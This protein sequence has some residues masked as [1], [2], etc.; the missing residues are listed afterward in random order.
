MSWNTCFAPLSV[1]ANAAVG[2]SL[3]TLAVLAWAQKE[4]PTEAFYRV[5]LAGC[6]IAL[7]ASAVIYL[8]QGQAL[9]GWANA[10]TAASQ[11]VPHYGWYVGLYLVLAVGGWL[12]D[13]VWLLRRLPSFRIAAS[14]A[15][16]LSLAG[17]F[18]MRLSFYAMHL[19]VGM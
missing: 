18:V 3:M 11:L 12:L 15:G 9:E 16:L 5:V 17:I 13:V 19:T 4:K 2:G 14:A 10:Y 8:A 6:G 1:A 7:V